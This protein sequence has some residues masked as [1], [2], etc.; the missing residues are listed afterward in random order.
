MGE[1]ASDTLLWVSLKCS[2]SSLQPAGAGL[3]AGNM[4]RSNVCADSCHELKS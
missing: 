2:A 1:S 3:L 4:Y